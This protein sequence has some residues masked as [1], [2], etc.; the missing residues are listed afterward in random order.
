MRRHD[1]I[2]HIFRELLVL[3]QSQHGHW[4]RPP[5]VH[6]ILQDIGS[7]CRWLM[8]QSFGQQT[9]KFPPLARRGTIV[10]LCPAACNSQSHENNKGQSD[11]DSNEMK[12]SVV[13]V[14]DTT[15]M[16]IAAV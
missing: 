6:A 7:V 8:A 12:S 16:I 10:L 1:E 3:L 15:G 5:G 4:L 14:G 13:F 9:A 2:G 11:L